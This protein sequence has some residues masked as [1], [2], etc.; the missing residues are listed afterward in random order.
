[1]IEF[2][3]FALKLRMMNSNKSANISLAFVCI[4]MILSFCMGAKQ[5]TSTR[6]SIIANL[7]SAL[8]KAVKMNAKNWLCRDTIQSYVKLQ[9]SIGKTVNLSM[10]NMVAVFIPYMPESVDSIVN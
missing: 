9:K 5:Y 6:D 8:G 10:Q 1:M 7:N 2:V 3:I 4:F